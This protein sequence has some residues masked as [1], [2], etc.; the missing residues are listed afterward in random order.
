MAG[1]M[2]LDYVCLQMSSV[3]PANHDSTMLY[4]HSSQPHVVSNSPDQ[5]AQYHILVL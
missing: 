3:S 1:E 4:I 5:A 2:S